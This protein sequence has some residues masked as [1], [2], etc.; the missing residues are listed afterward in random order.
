MNAAQV[1]ELSRRTIEAA[2][3]V[4][5]PILLSRHDRWSD[6]QHRPG[7]DLHPG[8]D[9]LH[10]AAPCRRRRHHF[11]SNA[12][13]AAS[14]GH[15]HAV[16][17]FRFSRIHPLKD[18]SPLPIDLQQILTHALTIGLRVGG[19][20]SFAPFLGSVSIPARIRAMLHYCP[21]RAAL[22]PCS[23]AASVVSRLVAW[24]RLALG[25]A[26]LGL[27]LGP[28]PSNLYSKARRW[29]ARLAG[30]QFAFS[31]V[32]VIDPQTNVETPVLSVFHQLVVLLLFLQLNVH[33]WILR[34]L[35]EEFCVRSARQRILSPP[36]SMKDLLHNAGAMW[37]T[38]VQLATPILACHRIDR[39]HRRF[40]EQ[41][42]AADVRH[43]P[44]H[45]A[46]KSDWLRRV[47]AS[48]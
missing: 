44:E 9:R 23:R 41:G 21:H 40:P 36:S 45:S 35:G 6:H 1:V 37:L 47:G 28:I 8:Y 11:F 34:G 15:F 2:F 33:H 31:L 20:M 16:A 10:R 24:T 12:L 22:S 17:V 48:R 13:D 27:A 30:F 43:L 3:W 26:I 14:P 32:N 25:E 29:R 7:H 39:R 18:R 38:G 42:V 5:A 46:E 19:I 4:A